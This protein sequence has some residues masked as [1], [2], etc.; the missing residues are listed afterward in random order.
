MNYKSLTALAV[1]LAVGGYVGY[2][3]YLESSDVKAAQGAKGPAEQAVSVVPLK[4]EDVPVRLDLNGSVASLKTVEVRAQTSNLIK[5]IHVKE[6]QFV[7]QG[8]LLFSLDDRADRANLERLKAQLAR[9]QALV[10]DYLRQYKRAQELRAQNF[11][12]ASALDTSQAQYEAQLALVKADEAALQAAQVTLDFDSIV[13]PQS[14]RLGGI[15]VFAGSL[16]QP[17]GAALVT[18]TQL[19]PIAVQFSIPEASL[20]NL[21]RAL[22]NK[23]GK[24]PVRVT[25]P[26]TTQSLTGHLYF[27]DS[28][29]DAATGTL[30]AKA[31]FA[32]PNNLLWPGQFVQTSLQLDTL[33]GVT[34]MPSAALVTNINGKFV[35]VLGEGNT[36][37]Q[38]PV[39]VL[40]TYGERM[41]IEG[42]KED[43]QV[44]LD[45]K[46]NLRP[47]VKVRLISAKPPVAK[48][49]AANDK[50]PAKP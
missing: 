35:Y 48:A 44:I 23:G 21:Q 18:I 40:Y 6:G 20:S 25:L 16:V 39:K 1:L 13:A 9:D 22:S 14:G 49:E 33:K 45:G 42:V 27:A 19:D 11:I 46:Q 7:K 2:N 5:K 26:G 24:A 3:R 10:A 30:R 37:Q 32:N 41:A 29:V 15:N 8:E 38:K 43:E 12:A 36:A 28:M 31:E 50:A 47:G 34:T 4:V 17:S